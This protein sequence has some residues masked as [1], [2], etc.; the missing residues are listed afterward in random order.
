M[1]SEPAAVLREY[2]EGTFTRKDPSVIEATVAPDVVDHAGTPGQPQGIEGFRSFAALV[3]GAFPDL[4]LVIEDCFGAGDRAVARWTATATHAGD[5]L[6]I[7]PTRRQVTMSG[8]DIAR[9]ADGR[10]VE[11][12]AQVDFAGVMAQLGADPG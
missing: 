8:I 7:R 12:W 10:I 11:L 9:V 3:L 5:L 1:A 4:D 6:G 2:L